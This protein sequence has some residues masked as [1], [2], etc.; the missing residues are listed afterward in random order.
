MPSTFAHF[1]LVHEAATA[2]TG[3]G[4][5][6]IAIKKFFPFALLGAN[7]PDFPLLDF[8]IMFLN[9]RWEELLHGPTA[10]SVIVPAIELLNSLTGDNRQRCLAWF[11]GYLS[12]MVGDATI[13][14]VV[15]LR[16]GPY[17]EGNE[18]DHQ[19]CEVHQDAHVFP[20]LEIGLIKKAEYIQNVVEVC[21]SP[22]NRLA[23]HHEIFDFWESLTQ[24]AFPN[25]ELPNFHRWFDSY[26]GIVDNLAEESDWPVIRSGAAFFG[27]AHLLH[28]DPA[29]KDLSFIEALPTP[30]EKTISYDE[31]FD[32]AIANTVEAWTALE[33]ALT[34][35]TA[36]QHPLSAQWDLNTGMID[37]DKYLY[38]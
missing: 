31:L 14:P 28:I 33:K 15:N 5:C 2:L 21:S 3:R 20:R 34:G 26:T 12:H 7:S 13:H 9:K 1:V 25:E 37:K 30:R 17:Y 27:K 11:C 22:R 16:V 29:E 4:Q 19:T 32:M 38:W 8:P 18:V 35:N 24:R 23:L 6:K 10:K 36:L